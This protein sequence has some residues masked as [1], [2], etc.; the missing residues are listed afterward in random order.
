M[1]TDTK[2]KEE[3]WRESILF[4]LCP[5]EVSVDDVV[6]VQVARQLRCR[7]VLQGSVVHERNCSQGTV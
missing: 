1:K 6:V 4:E 2:E 5:G 7:C 3:E